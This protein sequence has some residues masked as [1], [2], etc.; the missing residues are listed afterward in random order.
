MTKI[1]PK[2]QP[3]QKQSVDFSPFLQ[4]AQ[5]D[6]SGVD[7]FA[8]GYALQATWSPFKGLK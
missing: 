1:P 2:I 8:C 6:K 7:I 5:N 4:K 3:E